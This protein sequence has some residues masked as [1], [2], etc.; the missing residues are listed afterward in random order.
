MGM[1]AGTGLAPVPL[2]YSAVDLKIAN[3][4][5]WKMDS[6]GGTLPSAMMFKHFFGPR[7][8]KHKITSKHDR[9]LIEPSSNCAFGC[10]AFQS[11]TF[12][13]HIVFLSNTVV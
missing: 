3:T 9:E 10:S 12:S 2:D 8:P 1:C 5:G 11:N 7:K 13:N 4:T 6:S